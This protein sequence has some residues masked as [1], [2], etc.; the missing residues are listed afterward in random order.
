MIYNYTT[1]TIVG[2]YDIFSPGGNQLGLMQA[3]GSTGAAFDE[4]LLP[5]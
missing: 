4:Y 1:N 3:S 5:E 2:N